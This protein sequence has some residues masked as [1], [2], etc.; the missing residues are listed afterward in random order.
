MLCT[1][2]TPSHD[3]VA[4]YN[5]YNI[6]IIKIRFCLSG[7]VLLPVRV[8]PPPT[9]QSAIP[10]MVVSVLQKRD[11]ILIHQAVPSALPYLSSDSAYCSVGCCSGSLLYD[12][13]CI[14]H[15]RMYV[16]VCMYAAMYVARSLLT[17][18][19]FIFVCFRTTNCVYK[20]IGRP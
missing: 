9:P 10:N 6:D 1:G 3:W 17:F 14:A 7:S 19:S 5:F 18:Y 16:H 12:V 11:V 8:S 4:S 15:C 13:H 20:A 2:I